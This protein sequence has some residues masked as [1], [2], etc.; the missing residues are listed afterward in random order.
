MEHEMDDLAVPL[1]AVS[2]GFCQRGYYN[3]KQCL[4]GSR[5]EE[6][7]FVLQMAPQQ[8]C[9]IGSFIMFIIK[10][11]EFFSHINWPRHCCHKIR[12]N[13]SMFI[14]HPSFASREQQN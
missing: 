14:L 5:L 9:V 6:R 11:L 2:R 7:S 4:N 3:S 10:L 8:L 13:D 1:T 12:T